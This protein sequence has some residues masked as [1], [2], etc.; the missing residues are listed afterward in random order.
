MANQNTLSH[1]LCFKCASIYTSSS[2]DEY[3]CPFCHYSIDEALYRK[4][5]NYAKIAL[6]Y[7]YDYRKAYEQQI[8]TDS[9]IAKKY[10]LSDPVTVACFIGVAALS[11]II[12]G[13]SYDLVK[14][15]IGKIMR[16]SKEFSDNIG[17]DK[18]T[19][20]NETDIKVFIQY[21]Q[22]FH[23]GKSNAV[24]EIKSEIEKER[25]IW[26]LTDT[27]YPVLTEGNPS[28]EQIHEAV[29]MAFDKYQNIDKPLPTDFDSFWEDVD[30]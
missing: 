24:D 5:L 4:I 13:A 7:G 25:I 2:A 19:V 11:G 23:E 30:R 15:V 3:I 1:A 16:S 14:R 17:Q 22:E 18:I 9:K 10:A 12:G 8:H 28:R 27:L 21:I 29:K 20:S 6:Y 26:N